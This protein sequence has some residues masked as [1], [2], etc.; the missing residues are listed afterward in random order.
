[1]TLQKNWSLGGD[2]ICIYEKTPDD[3][4]G[5]GSWLLFNDNH[6]LPTQTLSQLFDVLIWS[7]GQRAQF[8]FVIRA[9]VAA[10]LVETEEYVDDGARSGSAKDIHE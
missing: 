1:M 7:W 10:P 6:P 8:S 2:C 9:F 4:V 5:I 3:L